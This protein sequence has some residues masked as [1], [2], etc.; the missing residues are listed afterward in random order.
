MAK[1]PG[2]SSAKQPHGE[3]SLEVRALSRSIGIVFQT[4]GL[5]LAIGGCCLWSVSGSIQPAL[6]DEQRP[7]T[8]AEWFSQS[9]PGQ[10]C[11]AIGI[12]ASFLA[13]M[14][15]LAVGMGMTAEKRY[16]GRAAMIASAVFAI[17]WL[18]EI[19]ALAVM[20]KSIIGTVLAV[21]LAGLGAGLFLLAGAAARDLSLH[22]PPPDLHKAPPDYVDP[23][24]RKRVLPGD[25]DESID[26]SA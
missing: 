3:E 15:F 8:L 19:V 4:A 23:L 18:G 21:I 24:A 26:P 13:G 20:A 12:F 5:V 22:P 9:P 14:A 10:V 17:V 2:S 7:E 25:D 6:T 1:P 11:F 16:S